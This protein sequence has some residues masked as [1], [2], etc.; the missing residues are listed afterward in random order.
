MGTTSRYGFEWPDM[1]DAPQAPLAFETLAEDVETELVRLDTDASVSRPLGVVGRKVRTTNSEATTATVLVMT[2]YASVKAGRIYEVGTWNGG[3]WTGDYG[4]AG[5]EVRY[6]T[7]GTSPTLS[8]PLLV[9]A[10][11]EIPD[12]YDWVYSLDA[13]GLYAPTTDHTLMVGLFL[14]QFDVTTFVRTFGSATWPLV[15]TIEDKGV[16][17]ATSG[18]IH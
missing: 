3:L 11:T 13:V 5:L 4:R 10:E 15:L 6:T 7:N 2:T 14:K 9:S 17:P 16:A 1:P 18:T 8:S 12:P